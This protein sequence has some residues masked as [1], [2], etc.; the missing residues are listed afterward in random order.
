M[1]YP[2]FRTLAHSTSSNRPRPARRSWPPVTTTTIQIRMDMMDMM[3][4][5]MARRF[6]R[7]GSASRR[8][9]ATVTSVPMTAARCTRGAAAAGSS[10]R[11]GPGSSTLRP[12]VQ[13][14]R[15]HSD[16]HFL[17][18]FHRRYHRPES[19][20][21]SKVIGKV[22][23]IRAKVDERLLCLIMWLQAKA[24]SGRSAAS[25]LAAPPAA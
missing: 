4:T 22:I 24:V 18:R 5:A 25:T 19:G 13:G 15:H 17:A 12:S 2:P 16:R 10:C 21:S 6:G 7:V 1:L 9:R 20:V 8:D 11:S 23:G 3:T 14:L